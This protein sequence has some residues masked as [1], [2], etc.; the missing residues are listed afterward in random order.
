MD[1]EMRNIIIL[2]C[3]LIPIR[4]RQAFINK[5]SPGRL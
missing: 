2:G 5:L 4:V 1:K 3:S